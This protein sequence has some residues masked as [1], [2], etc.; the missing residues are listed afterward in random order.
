[1]CSHQKQILRHQKILTAS[2][3]NFGF[4]AIAHGVCL[5]L[6]VLFKVHM[7]LDNNKVSAQIAR[8]KIKSIIKKKTVK[9]E[10]LCA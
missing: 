10:L 6:V 3:S 4:L 2:R 9:R 1:M 5:L 7:L 8:K